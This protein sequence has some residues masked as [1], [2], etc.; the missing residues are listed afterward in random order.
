MA[1]SDIKIQNLRPK[2][3]RYEVLDGKG[4]FIRVGTSGNKSWIFRYRFGDDKK[5]RR[6]TLGYYPAMNL[7]RAREQHALSMQL[8]EAGIDPGAKASIEKNKKITAPTF[9]DLLDE[10]WR[11]ELQHKPTAAAQKRMITKDVLP[12]WEK[13][14]VKFITRRDAVLLL[15]KVRERAPVTGNRLQSVLARMFNFAA[16]RGILEFSPVVGMRMAKEKSRSRVLTDEEIKLLWTALDLENEKID[17]YVGTKLALKTILLTG[18][19]PGEVSGMTWDE[20]SKDGTW[21]TMPEE[22]TKNGTMQEV[23][24]TAMMQDILKQARIFSHDSAYVFTSPRSPLYHHKRPRV[25]KPKE[26]DLPLSRLGLSRAIQR[27]W[28][29]IGIVDPFTPH[30]LRRTLRTRLASLGVSDV[31]AE[32]VLGH[33]LQGVLAIYNRHDYQVEKRQALERWEANL[34]QILGIAETESN[35]IPFEAQNK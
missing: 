33:K 32:R 2:N 27:H 30:D 3:G 6:M 29:S 24:L 26:D 28:S 22:R 16:E 19:R 20:I 10:F 21:W 23:P 1:L 4:L 14:K 7:S 12:E 25:A 15:D 11:V 35:V 9:G 13:R 5:P 17:M 34:Q 31:V 18:Q 8:L